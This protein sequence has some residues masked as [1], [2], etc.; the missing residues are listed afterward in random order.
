MKIPDNFRDLS[1][2]CQFHLRLNSADRRTVTVHAKKSKI[3]VAKVT[4]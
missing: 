3:R 2:E 4:F 1:A